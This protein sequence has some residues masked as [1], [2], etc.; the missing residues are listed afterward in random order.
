LKYREY[1]CVP[2][3]SHLQHPV[4]AS[5]PGELQHSCSAN[6]VISYDSPSASLPERFPAGIPPSRARSG[7]VDFFQI[8][9]RTAKALRER[10]AL[11][12]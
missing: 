10:P 1:V 12:S 4:K 9:S 5:S 2:A 11:F 8:F 3:V 7:R 6:P